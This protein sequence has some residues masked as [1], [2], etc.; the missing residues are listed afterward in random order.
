[1]HILNTLI[2]LVGSVVVLAA[3]MLGVSEITAF[4]LLAYHD[5]KNRR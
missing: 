2:Y 4:L 3:L 1:M 5:R